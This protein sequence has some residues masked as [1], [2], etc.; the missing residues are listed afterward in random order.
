LTKIFIQRKFDVEWLT[1]KLL[2]KFA[3]FFIL[4]EFLG[5]RGAGRRMELDTITDAQLYSSIFVDAITVE[6]RSK[7]GERERERE[8]ERESVSIFGLH[9]PIQSGKP[10]VFPFVSDHRRLPPLMGKKCAG[11]FLAETIPPLLYLDFFLPP[12]ECQSLLV[13]L[14]YLKH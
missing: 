6:R 10:V 12:S 11:F 8:E 2:L 1:A 5:T 9:G 4:V 7:Y 13:K 3:F 14:L